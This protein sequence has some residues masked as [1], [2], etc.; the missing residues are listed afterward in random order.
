L[1]LKFKEQETKKTFFSEFTVDAITT[2]W[3]NTQSLVATR[4]QALENEHTKQV[5]N[6]ILIV[7]LANTAKSFS[8]WVDG[9][10][11]KLNAKSASVDK[12]RLEE[13]VAELKQ[14]AVDIK[15]H[16][17]AVDALVTLNN[18]VEAAEITENKHTELT[19]ETLKLKWDKLNRL[20][21]NT[22][23]LLENELIIKQHGNVS[24]EELTEFKD[25]FSHFDK[26]H[27]QVLTKLEFKSCLQA[28][29]QDPKDAELDDVFANQGETNPTGIRVLNF[30]QFVAYMKK[31]HSSTDTAES[32]KDAFK[33]IAGEK[34]FVTAADLSA[35]FPKE[36][37]DYLVATM[38]QYQ[39]ADPN[40]K[41]FDY[42][43]YTDRVY[44]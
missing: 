12:N 22:V 33:I 32:I 43:A 11:A 29:G 37:V 4:K 21:D 9:E 31:K 7:E 6:E 25:C 24:P 1:L 20:A 38:P 8:S 41:G 42:K 44:A 40:I 17:N 30:N 3:K 15:G 28:L 36:K 13:E 35:V 23:Q 26:D 2:K 39:G 19:L 10:E 5:N 27:D 16:S 34:E 14:L 18:N